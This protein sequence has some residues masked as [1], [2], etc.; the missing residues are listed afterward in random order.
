[1]NT[2]EKQYSK[3]QIKKSKLYSAITHREEKLLNPNASLNTLV[4]NRAKEVNWKHN[5]ERDFRQTTTKS[6][7]LDGPNQ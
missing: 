7:T 6:L 2:K 1:M 4:Q 5:K 3:N